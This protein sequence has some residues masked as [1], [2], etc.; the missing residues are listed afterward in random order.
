MKREPLNVPV[1][2][3]NSAEKA[4]VVAALLNFEMI[5]GIV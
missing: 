3:F 2:D 5:E 1:E 4:P